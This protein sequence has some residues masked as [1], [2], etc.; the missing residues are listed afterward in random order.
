MA[1][2]VMNRLGIEAIDHFTSEDFKGLKDFEN[3]D[4]KRGDKQGCVR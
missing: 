3:V 1:F 2:M 4:G